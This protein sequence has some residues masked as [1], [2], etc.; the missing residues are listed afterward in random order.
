MQTSPTIFPYL[1]NVICK[2]I[3]DKHHAVPLRARGRGRGMHWGHWAGA[4]PQVPSHA[5][6]GALPWHLSS[7]PVGLVPTRLPSCREG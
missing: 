1:K 2:K 4:G 7:I 6:T 5:G 3:A